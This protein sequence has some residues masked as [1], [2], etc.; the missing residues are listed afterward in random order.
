[1]EAANKALAAM[2][3]M[4]RGIVGSGKREGLKDEVMN[5]FSAKQKKVKKCAWKHSFVCLAYYEQ[6]RIP[7]T[8]GEKDELIKTGLGEKCRVSFTE[9]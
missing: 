7:T 9:S 1:M 6:Q 8:D 2:K 4:R 3:G 5:T